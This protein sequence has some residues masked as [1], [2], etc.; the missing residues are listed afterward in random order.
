MTKK[1]AL[2]RKEAA[3]AAFAA[4]R[5]FVARRKWQT[6]HFSVAYIRGHNADDVYSPT[7]IAAV[8]YYDDAKIRA[9]IATFPP[10]CLSSNPCYTQSRRQVCRVHMA[11]WWDKWGPEWEQNVKFLDEVDVC[12][13]TIPNASSEI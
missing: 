2:R 1:L 3:A 4:G 12:S 7:P 10:M 9:S 8:K 11:L 13:N 5:K 6:K